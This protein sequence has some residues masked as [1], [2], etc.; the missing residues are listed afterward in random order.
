MG[1]IIFAGLYPLLSVLGKGRI[2][3]PS[4]HPCTAAAANSSQ[5]DSDREIFYD[6]EETLDFEKILLLV[7]ALPPTH[8]KRS[9]RRRR[10]SIASR[11]CLSHGL[12]KLQQWATGQAA[13]CW[14]GNLQEWVLQR[15]RGSSQHSAKEQA[16]RRAMQ[17]LTYLHRNL[18]SCCLGWDVWDQGMGK[19]NK[20]SEHI[21]ALLCAH[22][23]CYQKEKWESV[24][25]NRAEWGFRSRVPDS[26]ISNKLIKTGKQR[27]DNA[28]Q[29]VLRSG[30][31]EQYKQIPIFSEMKKEYRGIKILLGGEISHCYW[32][33]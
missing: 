23:F 21:I 29:T 14:A 32:R 33:Y 6:S 12:D 27:S 11:P 30:D 4:H 19:W 10:C 26:A 3:C 22:L 25:L 15:Q 5:S 17:S 24:V 16:V 28:W 1:K 20:Q 31:A 7:R 18:S 13:V 8:L 2:L 9:N